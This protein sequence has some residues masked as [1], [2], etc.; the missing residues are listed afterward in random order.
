[1]ASSSTPGIAG[2][3]VKPEYRNWLALGHAL[4]TVLC[5][6]LRPFI[7]REMEAFHRNLTARVLG[8]CTCV[9]VPRR[10]PNEFQDMT[11]CPWANILEAYHHRYK[12]NWRQSDPG[13]WMDPALG[14]WEIA[15]LYLPDLGG[16]ADIKSAD[17][18]DITGIL[19]LMYW[20]NHFTIPQALIKDIRDTRNDKWVHVP[21]LE[22]PNAEKTVAFDSIENLLRSP[23]L[24]T[25]PDA[26]NALREIENLKNVSD[27]HIFE[28]QVVAEL[29]KVLNKEIS[30]VMQQSRTSQE[31]LDQMKQLVLLLENKLKDLEQRNG[32][33]TLFHFVLKGLESFLSSL[34]RSLKRIRQALMIWLFMALCLSLFVKLDDNTFI[35]DGCPFENLSVPFDTKEFGWF[36]YLN[37]AKEEF[38]GRSWLYRELESVFGHSVQENYL[39]GVLIIG[40]PGA[41]K[42]ALSA[43]LICSPTSSR[44]IHAHILGYHLCKYSD[45]NTQTA[46]R[47][48]RNLAEMIARR[49]PEYGFL[50]SNSSY[51]LRSLHTDC[52]NNQD[53]VGCFEQAVLSP[54]KSLTNVPKENWYLVIDAL[55]EC[56]TQTEFRLSIVYL[57]NNKLSRFPS[58]L[59]L[60]MTSRNESTVSFNLRSIKKLVIGPEDSRN[61]EDIEMFLT[62]R[63]YQDGPLLHR[64]KAWFGD[65]SLENTARLISLLLSKSQGNFLFVKEMIRH[66][67][68][69]RII[70]NDPHALPET[71]EELYYNY[72]QRLYHGEE[73]FKP[74]RR[75]LELLVATFQPLTPKEIFDVLRVQEA[76]LEQDYDFKNGMKELGHFL[77]YGKDDTVT[78]YHLSLTEWLTSDDGRNGLFYVNRIKGHEALCNFYFKCITEEGK[79]ALLKYSLSLAQHIAYGGWK[80]AYVEKFLN[81]PSQVVNSSDPE[82]NRTVLHLAATINNTDVL[83]L[84]LRHFSDIDSADNFGKTSAFLAA[85]HGLVDNLALMVKKGA[86]VNLRTKSLSSLGFESYRYIPDLV[87]ESKLKFRGATMLHAAAHAGHLKVVNFLLDNGAFISIANEVNLTALQIAAEKGHLEVVK[88]LHKAGEVADQTALHHAAQ[89]NKLDVVKYLLDVGVK[90]TCMRCDGS[91]HWLKSEKYRLQS[92]VKHVVVYA[93]G[94]NGISEN[95]R[96]LFGELFDDKHL[97]YCETALHSAISYGHNEVVKELISR[98]KSALACKDYSGR[99]P[100]HEA[101]RRNNREIVTILLKEDQTEVDSTCEYPPSFRGMYSIMNHKELMEYNQE[102]CHCGYTPLHL[103]A[104]YG[105]WEIAID[106]LQNKAMVESKD[107]LGVTP[108]HVATCH[109]H[110]HVVEVLVKFGVNISSKTSNG[111]TPLHSAAACGAVEVIDQLVYHGAILDAT[112][113][114][115]LTALHYCILNV[116]PSHLRHHLAKFYEDEN[117]YVRNTNFYRWL[118]VFINLI[119]LGS[120]INALDVHG[121]SVLHVAAKNG[122]ADAVNVLIQRK[123]QLDVLDRTGEAPLTAAIKNAAV[124]PKQWIFTIGDTI[125]QLQEYLS[126]HEMVIYLLLSS[127]ASLMICNHSGESLLNHAIMKNRLLILQLLLLNGA[128]VTCKDK[129]GRTPLLTFLQVGGDGVDVVLKRFNAPI[130]IKCGK[131]FNTSELHLICYTPPSMED[132]NF[133]QEILCDDH[134]CSSK[135]GPIFTYIE[136]H[137]LKYKSIDSCLDAEGFTPLHRAAQG[138]NTVAVSNLIRHGANQSSLSPDGYDALTLALLHAGNTSWWLSDQYDHLKLYRVSV[139]ALELLRHKMKTSGYQIICDSSKAEL[140][141]YHLAASRGLLHFIKEIFK[142]KDSHQLDVDCPNRDGITPMYLAKISSKHEEDGVFKFSNPWA[143]VVEFIEK[144]GG[145]MQYPSRHAEYNVIYY[146]LYDW[147]PKEEKVNLRPGVRELFAELVSYPSHVSSMSCYSLT[148][149][150]LEFRF[151]NLKVITFLEL[152]QQILLLKRRGFPSRIPNNVCLNELWRVSLWIDRYLNHRYVYGEL[153]SS[154]LELRLFY[155]IRAWHEERFFLLPCYKMAF[156]KFRPYFRDEKK[157]EVLIKQYEDSMLLWHLTQVCFEVTNSIFFKTFWP[158]F[159]DKYNIDETRDRNYPD[160][161]RERMGWETTWE[162]IRGFF[163][164]WPAEFVIRFTLGL[165]RQYDYLKILE[166]GLE[167]GSRVSIH[168]GT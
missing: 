34:V 113:D 123:S 47:F 165:Y 52:A 21:R 69:T 88:A 131:P 163:R 12:P 65:A 86:D 72:F 48:V 24:A 110:Q 64:V 117:N 50:V 9:H 168:K 104:R 8:P 107:C 119:L 89:N 20:C 94:L 82:S 55:D 139:V 76:N 84:L 37:S 60:V 30:L 7:T 162:G 124:A 158:I 4:T 53:P 138:A 127:G 87:L 10:R 157:I 101:V 67:E 99:T 102:M 97:I 143:R 16:H 73:H 145:H 142:D 36:D 141:L 33:L 93:G 77:R 79:P 164:Y 49:I 38:I 92:K 122:L 45:K 128:S 25:D 96:V 23:S 29:I 154:K 14:P 63:F 130:E 11:T 1:M 3:L 27:L 136:N 62:T 126:D 6:G 132:D 58:W 28:A 100:L 120:N 83:E 159:F 5:Q 153:N 125:D 56:L 74:V 155:M 144:M 150:L 39:T 121:R 18:M 135:N 133:F 91:F 161:I 70:K 80:E 26:Q 46:G 106:L 2:Q 15:K 41:G 35:R 57:L 167:P 54:L 149:H 85:E 147:I 43:Q 75:I 118:D 68:A 22:L 140:T 95:S 66:W 148:S 105:N 59:K 31:Q 114:S 115:N 40:D 112:D 111:S 17:D 109:N 108:L 13:K 61:T 32:F 134:S 78:L 160:F 116:Q 51:I 71:I 166:V 156:S 81:F 98:D 42:S 44:I 151:S 152:I 103:T 90:D 146:R 19:N 137:P 129:Q